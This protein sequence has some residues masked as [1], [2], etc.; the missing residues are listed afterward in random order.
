ME[1]IRKFSIFCTLILV[2]AGCLFLIQHPE[3]SVN[4]TQAVFKPIDSFQQQ[5]NQRAWEK[6]QEDFIL[7]LVSVN[8][9]NSHATKHGEDA[10]LVRQS[11][12]NGGIRGVYRKHFIDEKT[13]EEH[14]RVL[15]LCQIGDDFLF[16]L[17]IMEDKGNDVLDE[18][19][20][21]I[22]RKLDGGFYT[23]D[24]LMHYLDSTGWLQ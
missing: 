12:N 22:R 15:R 24:E 5:Y 2:I 3:I 11:C 21:F 18:I 9:Q 16:G 14:N 20:S 13:G 4:A 1:G 8:Y 10:E 6:D 19:T 17:Q 7:V 23:W